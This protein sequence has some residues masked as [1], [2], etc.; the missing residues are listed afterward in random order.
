MSCRH[1][2]WCF[3]T[4]L[5]IPPDVA[6]SIASNSHTSEDAVKRVLTSQI[7]NES[8]PQPIF[9]VE[10]RYKLSDLNCPCAELPLDGYVKSKIPLAEYIMQRWFQAKWTPVGG[11]CSRSAEYIKFCHPDPNYRR[12][13]LC[14]KAARNK[15][16]R[17]SKK[18]EV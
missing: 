18:S 11:H 1:K 12:L 16:G 10:V 4:K 15:R 8:C 7:L 6:Q 13:L 17:P 2:S 5:T 9:N 14:E 3:V